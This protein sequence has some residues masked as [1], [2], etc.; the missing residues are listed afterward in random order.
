MVELCSY[1]IFF[2]YISTAKQS[3]NCTTVAALDIF[4]WIGISELLTMIDLRLAQQFLQ[5]NAAKRVILIPHPDA[6]GLAGA[7][8]LWRS[9][10]G[11]RLVVCSEKGESIY[12]T[13]FRSRLCEAAPD[14][15]VVI[16]QGSRECSVL[17][18]VPTLT[19][20][21]HY[22]SGIPQGVYLNSYPGEPSAN[23][24]LLCYHLVGCPENLL[25]L[26]AVG[27]IGDYTAAAVFPELQTAS[28]RFNNTALQEVV[29][30]VNAARRS[31]RHDWQ[32]AFT[33][34]LE[35]DDPRQIA[36]GELPQVSM[37]HADREEVK[38]EL[39]RARKA[40]PFL[41]DPWAVIPF[42]SP[43]LIHSLVTAS[44]LNRLSDHFVIAANFGY[45]PGYVHYGIRSGRNADMIAKLR[46]LAPEGLPGDWGYG[47]TA[48]GGTMLQRDFLLLLTRMGFTPEQVMQLSHIAHHHAQAK[49]CLLH[50][51][52]GVSRRA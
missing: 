42:S 15:V 14:A 30:L 19:I 13:P 23:A 40:H 21:H 31:S 35:A 46:E 51:Q 45:R 47:R 32:T 37:L 29:S 48:T 27:I 52:D 20:D 5:E 9:L 7:A 2:G 50:E 10:C 17:P 34:L 8:I 11:E 33:T 25:W 39:Q 4:H 1:T 22:P 44:W 26:A 24:A 3:A 6:D 38:H 16:D 18:G 49:A 41:A 43:C 36:D 12:S 28:H